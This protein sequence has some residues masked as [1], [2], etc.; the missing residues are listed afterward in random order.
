MG[1]TCHSSDLPSPAGL[2]APLAWHQCPTDWSLVVVTGSLAVKV[3]SSFKYFFDT[4][5]FK[6]AMTT[7]MVTS[8]SS[9]RMLGKTSNLLFAVHMTQ[10]KN[11]EQIHGG[12]F[13]WDQVDF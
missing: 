1:L 11:Y 2:L 9:K 6:T 3:T 4:L 10:L 8:L 7:V 13:F 5:S 12:F